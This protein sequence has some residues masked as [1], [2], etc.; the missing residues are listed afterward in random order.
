M[1]TKE[2]D[3]LCSVQERR[4]KQSIH[5]TSSDKKKQP[6]TSRILFLDLTEMSCSDERRGREIHELSDDVR[7]ASMRGSSSDLMRLPYTIEYTTDV[8]N[9]RGTVNKWNKEYKIEKP[10]DLIRSFPSLHPCVMSS[11]KTTDDSSV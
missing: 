10:V 6:F 8:A 1:K 9:L 7:L 4:V 3:L 11:L 2:N 5:L